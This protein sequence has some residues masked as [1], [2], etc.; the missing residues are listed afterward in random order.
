[1][2]LLNL[3]ALHAEIR[4]ELVATLTRVA[5]SGWYVLGEEVLELEREIARYSGARF[6]VG[7]ASG[8]D[9]VYLALRAVGVGAG[10][11]V[12]TTPF[13]FFATAGSITL[14][15]ARP[16]FADIDPLT[17]NIDPESL[18]EVLRKTGGARAIIPVHLYGGSADL[19]PIL[20]LAS[21]YGCP[22]V[23]DGAQAIGAEYKGRRV[24]ALG[25]VGCISFFPSKNLGAFGQG[26]MVTTN[27]E[28]LA[29]DLAMRRVH[30]SRDKYHHEMVGVNSRLDTLQAALLRVKLRRLDSWTEARQRNAG[31]YCDLLGADGAVGL[32]RPAA[33]QTRHI[34]NQF[35][36]RCAER[37]RL[38]EHL[39][40]GGVASEVYY[41]V[42]LHLQRCYQNL[43]YREGAFPEA[44]KAAREV[45]AL[46]VDPT[47]ERED[48]ERVCHLI[49]SFYR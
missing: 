21:E 45:L 37:D 25:A 14:L 49:R 3:P 27:D 15:G 43:G 12:V 20:Q 22:V 9:A 4:D 17:F 33:Y 16:L 13:T 30:G 46:P 31:L 35:V 10:D 19:D 47:L 1:M 7:C 39:K 41:P 34:W 5:D 11:S 38:R 29:S 8:S 23:E 26:G 6:G 18:A 36:I 24:N 44:E 32:P 28:G 42:P 2:P 40:A 48:I